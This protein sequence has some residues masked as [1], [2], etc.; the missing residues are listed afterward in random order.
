MEEQIFLIWNGWGLLF[1]VVTIIWIVL[2]IYFTVK[3][4]SGTPARKYITIIPII[5]VPAAFILDH[6]V[7]GLLNIPISLI[8]GASIARL[9]FPPN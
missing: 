2:H 6:W 5:S 8:I 1:Q 7:V 4:G 9:L 3:F